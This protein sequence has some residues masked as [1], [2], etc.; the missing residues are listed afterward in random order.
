MQC[1]CIQILQEGISQQTTHTNMALTVC[2]Y[3]KLTLLVEVRGGTVVQW[4][5]PSNLCRTCDDGVAHRTTVPLRTLTGNVY[6]V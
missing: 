1:T 5:T 6:F 4:T 2:S 3:T